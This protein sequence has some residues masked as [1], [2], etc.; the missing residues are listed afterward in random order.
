M[1]ICIICV[2]IHSQTLYE[3]SCH[4]IVVMKLM[5]NI[6]QILTLDCWNLVSVPQSQ[7]ISSNLPN[8]KRPCLAKKTNMLRFSSC[9]SRSWPFG[10]F[11]DQPF[12]R[13]C[14]P[15]LAHPLRQKYGLFKGLIRAYKT[16]IFLGGTLG[17]GLFVKPW[18]ELKWWLHYMNHCIFKLPIWETPQFAST[19]FHWDTSCW[20]IDSSDFQ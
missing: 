18:N 12:G 3:I 1:T 19:I 8:P 4:W 7:Y 2:L 20:M 13:Y 5:F 11:W 16:L 17:R 10:S 9:W 14:Q 15:R 6:H